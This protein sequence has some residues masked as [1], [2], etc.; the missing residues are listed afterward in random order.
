MVCVC[1]QKES[2]RKKR[3]ESGKS[4]ISERICPTKEMR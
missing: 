3:E 1:I 4:I 2:G